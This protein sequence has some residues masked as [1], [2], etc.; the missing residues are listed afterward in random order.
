MAENS[1]VSVIKCP[2]CG[3]D[4][5][6]DPAKGA[7]A[8]AYCG[9]TKSVE[10]HITSPRDF[11]SERSDGDVEEGESEYECPNCGGSVTL[12]NYATTEECPYCG[13]TN[14]VKKEMLKGLKP[15]SILPF[16]V[17]RDAA[18]ENG[19]KWLKKKLFAPT[20]LKKNFKVDR[21]K[22]IYEP[23]FV[24][25]ANTHSSYEG[26]LGEYYYVTVRDAK[27]NSHRERRTRWFS[28]SGNY[29]KGYSDIVVEAASNLDQGQIESL[30]PY[31]LANAEQYKREYLAGFAAE[32]Y[33][34]SLDDSFVDAKEIM[35][36]DIRK[37][38]LDQYRHDVVGHLNV[39]TNYSGIRF[40]YT[41]L[42]VWVC[43]YKF[44]D[45]VWSFLVNGRTG[46]AAGKVPVS[47]PKAVFTAVL[48]AGV[49]AVL[50]WLF[51]FSGY[52]G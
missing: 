35:E 32:R 4:M 47:V 50:V 43:G 40:N 38:I 22:G 1:E 8:C 44:R 23:C 5:E 33:N 11:L 25:A 16:V 27:G 2:N 45:K 37:S 13:A 15:D 51:F 6:F 42:P 30:L 21:F 24:F 9:G 26:V 19:R 3:A 29:A 10:K 41:L 20:K 34:E 49:I 48:A 46:K 17:T 18:F 52:I 28:V 12:S 36:D 39:G 7:L 14:I 31:D